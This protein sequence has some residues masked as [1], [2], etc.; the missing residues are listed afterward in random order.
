[1]TPFARQCPPIRELALPPVVRIV[2]PSI[3]PNLALCATTSRQAELARLSTNLLRRPFIDSQVSVVVLG[4]F[5]ESKPLGRPARLVES[6]DV[7]NEDDHLPLKLTLQGL[8][9]QVRPL[10]GFQAKD[11]FVASWA[12]KFV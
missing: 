12:S 2:L 10:A 1:M 3:L 7:L 5:A 8:Q 11:G 9:D 6:A 4:E